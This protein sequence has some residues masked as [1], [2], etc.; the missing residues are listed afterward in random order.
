MFVEAAKAVFGGLPL[1]QLPLGTELGSKTASILP[2]S[3]LLT[4]TEGIGPANPIHKEIQEHE[5]DQNIETWRRGSMD[6]DDAHSTAPELFV[7]NSFPLP[8]RGKEQQIVI[9]YI[10]SLYTPE[11]D[12][13]YTRKIALTA[14]FA[15]KAGG[16]RGISMYQWGRRKDE[17]VGTTSKLRGVKPLP[18]PVTKLGESYDTGITD[19][20]GPHIMRVR[21]A[22]VCLQGISNASK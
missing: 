1:R 19:E 12:L 21:A 8:F 4:D 7:A 18:F 3:V 13:A 5:H 2:G 11:L 17:V 22:Y 9:P 14:F 16:V 10:K 20:S 15:T 6:S